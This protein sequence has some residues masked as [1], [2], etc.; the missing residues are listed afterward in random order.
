MINT[1]IASQRVHDGQLRVITRRRQSGYAVYGPYERRIVGTY[2]V[3]F[4]LALVDNRAARIHDQR[5][6]T[7]QVVDADGDLIIRQQ[8]ISLSQLST[9]ANTFSLEFHTIGQPRLEYRV[10]VSGVVQLAIDPHPRV[11]Y[12]GEGPPLAYLPQLGIGAHN[13]QELQDSIRDV[14]RLLKPYRARRHDKVRV[15][16]AGDGG[17][18]QLDDLAN[19]DTAFSFGINDEVSWDVAMADRGLTIY[20]FDHTVD[21]P[22]PHDERMIFAKK[23]IATDRG[24]DRETLEDLVAQH[25]KGA[26]RPNLLLKMDIECAEWRVFQE[27]SGTA[28]GRFSQIVCELHAFQNLWE[29]GWRRGVRDALEK[30]NEQYAVVHIHGNVCGGISSVAGV[31]IPNVLEATFVNRALYEVEET[32]ETFPGPLDLSCD[33]RQADLYLGT[34]RF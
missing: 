20:Q 23:M 34:F 4:M 9:T 17:Y 13:P 7:I 3:E 19:L 33:P 29:E 25:D 15:G 6:A 1:Q 27:T 18:V 5:C 32:D 10:W 24:P 21:A 12:L 28:L 26:E 14:M 11:T 16:R 30:L 22:L 8:D 2:Q 31:L